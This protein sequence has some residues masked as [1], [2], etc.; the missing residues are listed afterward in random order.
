MKIAAP[1]RAEAQFCPGEG[2]RRKRYHHLVPIDARPDR[3]LVVS[4][5]EAPTAQRTGPNFSSRSFFSLAEN[6]EI[7][8]GKEDF[9]TH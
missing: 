7:W 4:L 9:V 1:R 6:A 3:F 2:N 8:S 5:A